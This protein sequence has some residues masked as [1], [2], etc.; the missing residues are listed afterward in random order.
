MPIIPS[1][2]LAYVIAYLRPLLHWFSDQVY[3]VLL[4]QAHDQLLYRLHTH[5]DFAPL[6]RACAAYHH[7]D[8][9]GAPPTHPVPR[10]VRALLV[11][12]LFNWSLRQLEFQIRFNLL[13]KW[14]VGY[15]VFEGG[16]DH[17]TLERFE[18]WVCV[19]QHRTY[20]DELLRQIDADFPDERQQAQIGDTFALHANAAQE[21]RVR[22]LRHTCQRLLRTLQKARPELEV[23]VGTQ[24]A[25][26]ILFGTPDEK[27]EYYL[28]ATE[29]LVRLQ[30]TVL[31]VQTCAAW[32]RDQL[33]DLPATTRDSVETW[34]ARVDKILGDEVTITESPDPAGMPIVQPKAPQKGAYRI[35]SAT[36]PE[37][38]YRQHGNVETSALGYNVQVLVTDHFIREIQ[39]DPGAQPDPVG[40][41]EVLAA[42]QEYHGIVPP[43]LI[44]D[45]AAGPG[46]VRHQ[47]AEATQGQTQ[48]VA[49]LAQPYQHTGRFTPD[50]FQ[51][52]PDDTTLTCPQQQT[53]VLAYAS[54]SGDGRLFRF[55]AWQCRNCP[56][57]TQCRRDAPNTKKM[58][59]V[60]I[61]DYRPEVE[62]ARR[63]NQTADFKADM[64]RR[65]L[66]ER[67]IAALVRHNGARHARRCGQIQCDFQAKMNAVAY[68]AKK[69]MRLL[70]QQE[71]PTVPA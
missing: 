14:F 44:Y 64:K 45:A 28:N 15:P 20:F 25:N 37:A 4:P 34:L 13:V 66:V 33:T 71:T 49:R 57:W 54:S 8:G 12:Y 61:S 50:R 67:I 17:T 43:K 30:T 24:L 36:D 32:V 46:K 1:F 21:S 59:Q 19:H 38:T 2:V 3:L 41:P 39:A 18:L 70:K 5:L 51:L 29:R 16:P 53:S 68:N 55:L 48:L 23:A 47:V 7:T 65:P 31:A 9:P 63:Y 62:A 42:E 22:L 35:G 11:G 10:L 6:E 69:W 56:L 27:D 26:P 58:R 60:F 40:L 52:S